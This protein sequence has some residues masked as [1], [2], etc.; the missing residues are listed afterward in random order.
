VRGISG[1]R[2][3]GLRSAV[4][5]GA[6]RARNWFTLATRTYYVRG[7]R[8]V[9][10]SVKLGHKVGFYYANLGRIGHIEQVVAAKQGLRKG[11]PARGYT[12]WAGNTGTG[13]GREG[14]RVHDIFYASTDLYAVAD[15][16]Y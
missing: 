7:A 4:P 3:K 10:D 16:N 15:W 14:A 12:I 6:G 9:P 2:A 11:R 1:S 13:G 5:A 8:G